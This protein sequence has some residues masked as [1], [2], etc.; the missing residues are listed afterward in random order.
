MMETLKINIP[1]SAIDRAKRNQQS[2]QEYQNSLALYVAGWYLECLQVD[3]QQDWWTQYLSN[4]CPLELVGI[5]K[6]ECVGV[7]GESETIRLPRDVEEDRVGYLFI[8]LNES[9]TSAEI[10]GFKK[11]YCEV[12]NLEELQST[13][14]LID[15]L[16]Q[17]ESQP[18][19]QPTVKLGQ[20]IQ[21]IFH[22][23]WEEINTL[24][25]NPPYQYPAV[26]YRK[27]NTYTES[28]DRINR[29]KKIKLGST[30]DSPTVILT[31]GIVQVDELNSDIHL[32]IYSDPPE[33]TL[34]AGIIF[35]AIDHLGQE[36]CE[37]LQIEAGKTSGEI[38][39]KDGQEGERFSVAIELDGVK[40]VELFEI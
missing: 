4:T 22:D 34:P 7:T 12:V 30:A 40:E 21:R 23:T 17:L 29:G 10:L 35:S 32:Q 11:W 26:A 19:Q 5:G 9:L 39:L 6:L 18:V 36:I 8:K 3:I 33:Q 16:C 28:K 1:K 38:V 13:D 37:P 25:L 24:C 27:D 2:P 31:V 14:E 15:Y 20:W